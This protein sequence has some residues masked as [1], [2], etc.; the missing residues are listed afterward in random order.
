MELT[1]EESEILAHA[2]E[3]KQRI[4]KAKDEKKVLRAYNKAVKFGEKGDLSPDQ[5]RFAR[6][7]DLIEEEYV[8]SHLKTK[9]GQFV[10]MWPGVAKTM[11]KNLDVLEDLDEKALFEAARE[12]LP[13]VS[14]SASLAEQI[15]DFMG[16]YDDEASKLIALYMAHVAWQVWAEKVG[17]E[18]YA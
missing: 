3:I 13:G 8:F 2:E 9:S 12:L 14:P 10:W 4:R 6:L 16:K 5:R 7:N 11:W 1:P 18:I 15:Y 17:V